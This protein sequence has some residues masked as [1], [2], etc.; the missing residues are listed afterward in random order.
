[1]IKLQG[2][3][4]ISIL[5]TEIKVG[6]VGQVDRSGLVSCGPVGDVQFV[7]VIETVSNFNVQL[8]LIRERDNNNIQN[9]LH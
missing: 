9:F 3:R 2:N 6:M 8:P 7:F 5:D 1:M 4:N